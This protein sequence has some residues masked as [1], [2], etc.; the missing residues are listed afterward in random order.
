MTEVFNPCMVFIPDANISQ[1]ITI[2][3]PDRHP[4]IPMSIGY[5]TM[6]VVEWDFGIFATEYLNEGVGEFLQHKWKIGAKVLL[7]PLASK[8]NMTIHYMLNG[9]IDCILHG[10]GTVRLQEGT[11]QM[12]YLPA[13]IEQDAHFDPGEYSSFQ[14]VFSWALLEEFTKESPYLKEVLTAVTENLGKGK[15]L[16]RTSISDHVL[17]IF[18]KIKMCRYEGIRRRKFME[19]QLY[20]LLASYLEEIETD[21]KEEHGIDIV[22]RKKIQPV[23]DYIRENLD[24]LHTAEKLAKSLGLSLKTF[25]RYFLHH[26]GKGFKEYMLELRLETVKVLLLETNRGL[27]DI[28][29][30]CGFYDPPMLIHRFKEAFGVT[31]QEYRK[32]SAMVRMDNRTDRK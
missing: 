7:H 26:V 31:P 1:N 28:A 27:K 11:A 2:S 12:F 6:E 17:E 13:G 14:V 5:S 10:A 16:D 32:N 4:L 9:N 20:E 19:L 23:L 22:A 8:S 30:E 29:A 15:Q 21:I 25:R 24:E 3:Y 18:R